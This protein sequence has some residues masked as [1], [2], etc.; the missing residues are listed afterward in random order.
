MEN[1]TTIDKQ[2]LS[3]IAERD[4]SIPNGVTKEQYNASIQF[5]A[6]SELVN[7]LWDMGDFLLDAIITNKGRRFL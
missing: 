6:E 5:L 7:A 1:L 4:M 2:I 3:L